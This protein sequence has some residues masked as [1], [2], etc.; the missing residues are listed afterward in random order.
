MGS[1]K[2]LC[3]I[4]LAQNSGTPKEIGNGPHSLEERISGFRSEPP[5]AQQHGARLLKEPSGACSATLGFETG[6][7]E[8]TFEESDDL[9]VAA[10]AFMGARMEPGAPGRAVVPLRRLKSLTRLRPVVSHERRSLASTLAVDLLHRS[11]D[12]SVE[13]GAPL[14]ELSVVRDL[15]SQRVFELVHYLGEQLGLL[16]KLPGPDMVSG[17]QVRHLHPLGS[18]RRS[19]L[20]K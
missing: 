4:T 3:V 10:T 17:C 16:E 7:I 11:G 6:R 20:W 18:L 12:L 1:R 13:P 19:C 2:T 15:P 14:L 8:L 9:L 5:A